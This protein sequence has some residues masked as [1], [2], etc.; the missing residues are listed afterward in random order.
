MAPRT[1]YQKQWRRDNPE[2]YKAQ[3]DRSNTKTRY[4]KFG[5]TKEIFD[6]MFLAQDSRC[7]ICETTENTSS[8]DWAIDHCHRTGEVRGILCHHCNLMLGNAKD[9]TIRLKKAIKY[10]NENT[11][12][13]FR[14]PFSPG[15]Q[16]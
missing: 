16:Q 14:L 9:D 7:A 1:E 10:L 13:R 3:Q 5:I 12:N 4:K 15:S 11:F 8:K 2:K 6:K